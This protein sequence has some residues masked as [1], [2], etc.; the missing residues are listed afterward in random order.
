MNISTNNFT[1]FTPAF[2]HS[3]P[4]PANSRD[5]SAPCDVGAVA[6][7]EMPHL[8]PEVHEKTCNALLQ[9]YAKNRDQGTA[10][11]R[12]VNL[13]FAQL[14]DQLTQCLDREGQVLK[15]KLKKGKINTNHLPDAMKARWEFDKNCP[16]NNTNKDFIP[17]SCDAIFLLGM[18]RGHDLSQ[19][20]ILTSS[21]W[22]CAFATTH[23]PFP[24]PNKGIT[25]SKQEMETY[26]KPGMDWIFWSAYRVIRDRLK[27]NPLA[28]PLF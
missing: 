27:E 4:P 20:E 2:S 17:L 18:L 19:D 24:C 21:L 26:T 22:P 11:R 13:Q 5:T 28:D 23:I 1:N 9:F 8:D 6:P 14:F 7:G 3:D 10:C 15:E 12:A 25:L 16:P